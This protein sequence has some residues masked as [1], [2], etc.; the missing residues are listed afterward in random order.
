MFSLFETS[1]EFSFKAD[2]HTTGAFPLIKIMLKSL[3]VLKG[4]SPVSICY[5]NVSHTTK[6]TKKLVHCKYRILTE[7]EVVFMY[8]K[9]PPLANR[10]A[11]PRSGEALRFVRAGL[12]VHQHRKTRLISDLHTE[13]SNF[14]DKSFKLGAM[15]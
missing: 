15:K 13:E 8:W 6:A 14:A 3:Y 9:D 2:F 10:D 4:L 11:E 7:F 1:L 5:H 12:S